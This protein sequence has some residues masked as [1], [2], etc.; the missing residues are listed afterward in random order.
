MS[1]VQCISM[2]GS[3]MGKKCINTLCGEPSKMHVLELSEGSNHLGQICTSNV[4]IYIVT[5][6]MLVTC[7]PCVYDT[8]KSKH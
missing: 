8:A 1:I 2:S 5:Q 6:F 4:L 3:L 7:N